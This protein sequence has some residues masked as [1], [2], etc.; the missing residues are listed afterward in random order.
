MRSKLQIASS[1]PRSGGD[2]GST[3]LARV[4]R[5]PST[6]N[7][8]RRPPRPVQL[9]ACRP[10]ISYSLAELTAGL[11]AEPEARLRRSPGTVRS[12]ATELELALLAIPAE[13]YV[14][15]LVGLTP[16]REG[17]VLCPFHSETVPSFKLYS[18]GSFFCFGC[19]R[20]GTIFDFAAH[21]WGLVPRGRGFAE[22]VTLLA[23]CFAP[24]VVR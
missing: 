10:E 3:D 21:L 18:D 20:G 16:N 6:L 8:K 1:L 4:L 9:L 14:L 7:H 23:E 19:R 13:D 11:P 22:I 5:P 17:K 12:Q 24:R 2:L 15:I